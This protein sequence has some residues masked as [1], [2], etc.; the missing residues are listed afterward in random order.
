MRAVWPLLSQEGVLVTEWGADVPRQLDIAA[1]AAGSLRPDATAPPPAG[2]VESGPPSA[3]ARGSAPSAVIAGVSQASLG[4]QLPRQG[5]SAAGSFMSRQ[6]SVRRERI[7]I[8]R[9]MDILGS[10]EDDLQVRGG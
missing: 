4:A 2:G 3:V 8:S 5:S 7:N 6:M 10:E 1:Q 9:V